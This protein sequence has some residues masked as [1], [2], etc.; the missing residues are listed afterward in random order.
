MAGLD[1]TLHRRVTLFVAGRGE[2][3]RDL[4]MGGVGVMAGARIGVR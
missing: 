2:Y 3:R 1:V 4:S